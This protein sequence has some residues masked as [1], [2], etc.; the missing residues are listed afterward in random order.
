MTF[1]FLGAW[2][3]V[4]LGIQIWWACGR[5]RP[6]QD[7]GSLSSWQEGACSTCF[8]C[9]SQCCASSVHLWL[10]K[11]RDRGEE[12]TWP[13][14]AVP[15]LVLVAA[16]CAVLLRGHGAV[17]TSFSRRRAVLPVVSAGNKP[18]NTASLSFG[19]GAVLVLLFSFLSAYRPEGTSACD[20]QHEMLT[21][22]RLWSSRVSSRAERVPTSSWEWEIA[23]FLSLWFLFVCMV[24]VMLT[25]TWNFPC[26]GRGSK[27]KFVFI[28]LK[29]HPVLLVVLPWLHSLCW[30]R[31]MVWC[32]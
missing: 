6:Q 13:E 29:E 18:I 10:S 31:C 24:D 23:S 32:A 15:C 2:T 17:G 14:A 9:M 26:E 21:Q 3:A 19:L 1:C 12:G 27:Q 16:G 7:A 22:P 25:E 28:M 5:S 4:Q 20:L 8:S 30:V 11:S